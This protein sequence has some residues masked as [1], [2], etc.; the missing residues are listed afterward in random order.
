MYE[1]KATVLKIVDGDT[2][3]LDINLGFRVHVRHRVR[4]KGVD[5]PE[6]YGVRHDSEEYR[7]GQEASK[8]VKEWI[9]KCPDKTVLVRSEK[10]H[11]GK[12]GRWIVTIL[13][14]DGVK[15]LNEDLVASGHAEKILM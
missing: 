6:I 7:K 15:N 4:L 5:T 9:E 10:D 12:Y 3:D 11:Q 13:S 1:Y 14:E 2:L 8:F